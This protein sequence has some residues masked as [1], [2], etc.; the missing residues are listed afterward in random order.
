M[1][2]LIDRRHPKTREILG[3][4]EIDARVVERGKN[5]VK[6]MLPDGNVIK[7]KKGRDYEVASE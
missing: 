1:K 3:R 7:R 4:I 2:V 6:V 5:S